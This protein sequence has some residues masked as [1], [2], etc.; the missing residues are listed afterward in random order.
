VA[1]PPTR[2]PSDFSPIGELSPT[3]RPARKKRALDAGSH[4]EIVNCVTPAQLTMLI[5]TPSPP[6]TRRR[7]GKGSP[8][9]DDY[10]QIFVSKH[11][12]YGPAERQVDDKLIPGA[13]T[14][15]LEKPQ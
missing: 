5:L 6:F 15:Q 4:F 7:K 8:T 10:E 3:G 12:E 2:P 14:T 9:D 11:T 1:V 13:M